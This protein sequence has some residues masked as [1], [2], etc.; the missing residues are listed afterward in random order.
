MTIWRIFPCP[1]QTLAGL[2]VVATDATRPDEHYEYL[3]EQL[4]AQGYRGAVLFDLLTCN[5]AGKRR[6]FLLNFTGTEFDLRNIERLEAPSQEVRKAVSR[7]LHSLV[8][9]LD[10][11][12]LS[13]AQRFAV[14]N[15]VVL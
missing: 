11:S 1:D 15:A 12:V 2:L 5:G 3:A 13:P 10:L 4:K 14:R 7:L 8:R 6:F 9:E